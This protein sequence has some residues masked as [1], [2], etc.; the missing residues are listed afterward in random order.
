LYAKLS[1]CA[2]EVREIEYLGHL[3]SAAGVVTD[4]KKIEAMLDWP[5]PTNVKVLRGFLG[6]ADYYRKF[7]RGYGLLSKPL[8][9]LLKKNGFKWN[10]Q[11]TMAFEKLKNALSSAPV[12]AMPDF[13]QPF[14]LETD[15]SDVGLGAVL[16]QAKRP[17][18]FMSKALGVKN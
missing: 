1:K 17:I 7:I 14:I 9:D 5:R 18:A 11:A 3:I 8:T 6:L 15:A 13:S 16:M 4:P 10:P 12:L 2:F